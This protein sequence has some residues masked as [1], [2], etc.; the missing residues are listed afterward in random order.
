MQRAAGRSGESRF[1]FDGM[2]QAMILDKVA[3]D[4][5]K[6]I[7]DEGVFLEDLLKKTISDS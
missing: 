5:K 6:E 7:F 2:L 3:P 4:W 1:Y